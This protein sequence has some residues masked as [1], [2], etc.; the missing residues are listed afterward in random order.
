MNLLHPLTRRPLLFL[1]LLNGIGD[2]CG[3]ATCCQGVYPV[4]NLHVNSTMIVLRFLERGADFL[5]YCLPLIHGAVFIRRCSRNGKLFRYGIISRKSVHHAGTRFFTRGIDDFGNCANFVETE[6]VIETG[7]AL[8]AFVQTR[9]SI[10]M[11]WSQ[12]YH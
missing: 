6:Q 7:N 11:Y 4:S 1:F 10:P 12:V 3:I 2:L 9:G 8:A 5:P